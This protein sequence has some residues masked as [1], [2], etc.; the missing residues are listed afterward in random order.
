MSNQFKNQ[1]ALLLRH[2]SEQYLTSS[3]HLAHFLRQVK[4]NPQTGHILVGKSAFK[5]WRG[6]YKLSQF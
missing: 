3:Q 1:I 4:D 6:I 5:R 2:F